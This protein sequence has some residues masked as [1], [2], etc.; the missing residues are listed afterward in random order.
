[1]AEVLDMR[2]PPPR[3]FTAAF[4]LALAL[5]PPSAHAQSGLREVSPAAKGVYGGINFSLAQP[6]GAFDRN[7]NLSP[8][9]AVYVVIP[10]TPSG[11]VGV[12][13]QTGGI[14][15]GSQSRRI[16]LSGTGGLV[17]VDVTT[18]NNLV[19]LGA[20]VLWAPRQGGLLPYVNGTL[21]GSYLF[22]Q[23]SVKGSNN[24]T[25]FA[26]STNMEDFVFA[27]TAGGGIYI[28]VSRKVA[29][30]LGAQYHWGG[31]AHYLTREGIIDNGD[32][33]TSFK[34]SVSRTNFWRFQL[35]VAF[36]L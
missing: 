25:S 4:V 33:T 36:G 23:S 10:I 15:Y 9:G 1:M 11:V 31:T 22:T 2:I 13:L 20:G 28:P 16:P 29:L 24:S 34:T 35:G 6:T 17:A 21:G 18:T 32:G 7:I 19:F 5:T 12:I 3:T 30:D 26:S 27:A 14:V 8:G